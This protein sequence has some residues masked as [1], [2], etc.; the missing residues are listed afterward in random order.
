MEKIRSCLEQHDKC[1]ANCCRVLLL[2]NNNPNKPLE[3]YVV[4]TSP[5]NTAMRWYYELRGAK[6]VRP[7][8][9]I[10]DLEQYVVEKKGDDLLLW[11]DCDLLEGNLCKGHPDKKPAFCKLLDINNPD[12]IKPTDYIVDGCIL[13]ETANNKEDAE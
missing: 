3:R 9:I 12:S 11:R 10:F 5:R 13:K 8:T 6:Y 4:S 2:K 7:R 1:H